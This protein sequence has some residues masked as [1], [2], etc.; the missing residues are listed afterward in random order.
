[1]KNH[2]KNNH[3]MVFTAYLDEAGGDSDYDHIMPAYGII[4]NH[5]GSNEF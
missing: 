3:P 5:P 4:T 1:M 2:I